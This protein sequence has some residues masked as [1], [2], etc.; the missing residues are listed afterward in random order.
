[1]DPRMRAAL[2]PLLATAATVL[3][4][5]ACAGV[6]TAQDADGSAPPR[7]T[8]QGPMLSWAGKAPERVAA[9]P[10]PSR[11]ETPYT[12]P[13]RYMAPPRAYR[14]PAPESA[15]PPVERDPAPE[16]APPP[17]RMVRADPEPAPRDMAAEA[18]PLTPAFAP[19]VPAAP[20]SST[21]TGPRFYSLHRA[22]GLTPDPIPVP[23]QRP[24]VLVGPPDRYAEPGRDD[25]GADDDA[26][27][28]PAAHGDGQ[29]ADGAADQNGDN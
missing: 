22:Y 25:A 12:A 11:S 28:K 7:D 3:A 16:S 10:A 24:T 2:R 23:A 4:A 21:Q 27:A 18:A 5:T 14:E 26:P 15:P 9:A 1:M 6:T 19:A 8:Y 20:A 17:R 29:G 13:A